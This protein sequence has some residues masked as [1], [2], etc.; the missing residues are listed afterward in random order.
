VS[1][2]QPDFTAECLAA[3]N[4][5]VELLAV[6][7]DPNGMGRVAGA[8]HR[9]SFR[10]TF[11]IPSGVVSSGQNGNPNFEGTVGITSSLPWPATA[12]PGARAFHT[13]M[14]RYASST[15]LNVTSSLGWAAGK[16]F[17]RA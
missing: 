15:P 4:A 13:A 3:R 17:E 12:S 2:A 11:V 8:C 9:Q 6:A 1:I 16:L 14:Q 5:G 10:P 7:V